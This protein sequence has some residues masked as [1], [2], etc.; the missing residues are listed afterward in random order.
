VTSFFHRV[1]DALERF[2]IVIWFFHVLKFDSTQAGPT[3]LLGKKLA[4]ILLVK[5]IV[6]KQFP[7]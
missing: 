7:V 3:G 1:L 5:W 2:I 4:Y 6:N